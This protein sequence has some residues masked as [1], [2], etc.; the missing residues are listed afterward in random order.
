MEAL[1]A[2]VCRFRE[3]F[4]MQSKFRLAGFESFDFD[5]LPLN[6]GS[7]AR[8]QRLE[9]GFFGGETRSKMNCR[10]GGFLAI[11]LL[12]FCIYSIEEAVAE[13]LHGIANAIVLDDVDA[14]AGNHENPMLQVK[15]ES[16]VTFIRSDALGRVPGITHGFSTRR[17]E[18]NLFT[19]GPITSPNP[20]V[21]TNRMR[22]LAVLGGP[23]WPIMK[24]KQVHSGI[25]VD[26]D[27]TAAANEPIEGDAA[28]TS[29]PG[30]MLAVQT[31]DCVP[32]LIADPNARAV[33]AVHAGWRGTAAR[34]VEATVRRMVEKFRVD[35]KDLVAAIGPHISGCC[36][37]VGQ[38]VVE[39]IGDPHAFQG[40]NLNLA[41]A[42]RTQLLAAGLTEDH[43]EASSLCTK[44]RQDLF[45][46]YR[47]EGSAAGRMLSV[48]GI[49]P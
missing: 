18:H 17:A 33:A 47:R 6:A 49:A 44:C 37:E 42:N 25:I 5:V 32:V 11:R 41:E 3:R 35:P 1:R 30:V 7:P 34:I 12:S 24:L 43:I 10:V 9:G 22:F 28:V 46:S 13:A 40:R 23:G 38:E 2:V 4:T 36:Y 29:L 16:Q 21:Q 31:A 45:F 48:I 26:I 19:L 27:D 39:A 14:N 20:L 15:R 8:S